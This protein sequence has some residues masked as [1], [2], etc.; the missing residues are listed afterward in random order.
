[1][2]TE[3]EKARLATL[4]EEEKKV[5]KGKLPAA[6]K[7]ELIS[8]IKKSKGRGKYNEH[9]DKIKLG[10]DLAWWTK[11][12]ALMDDASNLKSNWI[13]GMALDKASFNFTI[14]GVIRL[15]FQQAYGCTESALEQI[16]LVSRD[17]YLKMF[18]KYRGITAYS[19][20]DVGIV[21][22]A[23]CEF[24][25]A[26][27]KTERIYGILNRYSRVNYNMP[28]AELAALG[29]NPTQADAIRRHL[30]DFRYNLNQLIM[31]A[32]RLCVPKDLTCI[33]NAISLL[34]A[35]YLD[36]DNAKAQIIIFDCDNFGIFDETSMKTGGSV[37]FEHVRTIVDDGSLDGLIS[38][39]DDDVTFPFLER[40][41]E[42]LLA[43]D[44]VQKIYGDYIVWFGS[45]QMLSFAA[46]PSDYI[47]SPV[48]AESMLHKI[49]NI[50]FQDARFG[51]L[52]LKDL[53]EDDKATL[54]DD[55]VGGAYRI[56]QFNDRII[57]KFEYITVLVE[58]YG[59]FASKE[60]GNY[61]LH[62]VSSGSYVSEEMPITPQHTSILDTYRADVSQETIVEGSLWKYAYEVYETVHE[63][64][65]L[66]DIATVMSS[67]AFEMF[68]RIDFFR[69]NPADGS[70]RNNYNLYSNIVTDE[71][72]A[73]ASAGRLAVMDWA[74][75][76][77]TKSWI[78]SE[79]SDPALATCIN[80]FGDV[81]T[82]I[83]LPLNTKAKIQNAA[84]LS[85]L[86][87][88][89]VVVNAATAK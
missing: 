41:L 80:V 58:D 54:L 37:K 40:Q 22:I 18:Q 30:S 42:E 50:E 66:V 31:R 9:H 49:H 67:V 69:I 25:R 2:L 74:P 81:D 7:A 4:L 64:S 59:E 76:T 86:T 48:Y 89:I 24:V 6:E 13:P 36:H 8:L 28:T 45:D 12:S 44:S 15:K 61:I 70:V 88:D 19:A 43:S 65:D 56:Y 79:S 46:I 47:V 14:T 33:Q 5:G 78:N 84:V 75:L 53:S 26:L 71:D 39:T 21:N 51:S 62:Y 1:M 3:N 38:V 52:T 60:I 85:G 57:T 82:I 23:G 63:G 32:Q 27:T 11:Q 73:A 29:L 72:I 17:L 10:N 16:N 68:T 35:E 77:Y 55:T 87:T 34:G 20:S 83:P